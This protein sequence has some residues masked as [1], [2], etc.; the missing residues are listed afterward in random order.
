MGLACTKASGWLQSTIS[1]RPLG[2]LSPFAQGCW[3]IDAFRVTLLKN[4]H[5]RVYGS[6]ENKHVWAGTFGGKSQHY[7]RSLETTEGRTLRLD[8]SSLVKRHNCDF[9]CHGPPA[10]WGADCT[11][12]TSMDQTALMLAPIPSFWKHR[13]A[14]DMCSSS[15]VKDSLWCI[16]LFV[17]KGSEKDHQLW[18]SSGKETAPCPLIGKC[19]ENSKMGL[20][21]FKIVTLHL[22][23]MVVLSSA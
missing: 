1:S 2:H 6:L 10:Q 20:I 14:K 21:R 13:Y 4:G 19:Q 12:A 11:V 17:S 8:L 9:L 22:R 15:T 3:P 7:P 23:V 5:T 18:V 16:V